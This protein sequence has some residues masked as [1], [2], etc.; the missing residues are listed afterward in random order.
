MLYF[1]YPYVY[2]FFW[3]GCISGTIFVFP[4]YT[5]IGKQ[6]RTGDGGLLDNYK[7]KLKWCKTYWAPM[8][9]TLCKIDFA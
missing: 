9:H 6:S 8:T 4:H 3:P 7:A 1:V 2:G 5:A